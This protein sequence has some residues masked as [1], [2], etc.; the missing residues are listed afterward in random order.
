MIMKLSNVNE[1]EINFVKEIWSDLLGNIV[2][3]ESNDKIIVEELWV[4]DNLSQIC[5]LKVQSGFIIRSKRFDLLNRQQKKEYNIKNGVFNR[6]I[7]ELIK[8]KLEE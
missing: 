8:F 1:T 6:K 4:K 7:C 2:L 5:K 3:T